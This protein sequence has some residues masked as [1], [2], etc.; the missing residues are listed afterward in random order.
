FESP[1]GQFAIFVG[2]VDNG[3]PH[4]FEVWING[5]EQPRGLGAIAKTLSMDMRAR[6]TK[7]LRMKLDVLARAGGDAFDCAM[8]PD[9]K[10]V[11]VPSVV[12]AFARIVRYRIDFLGALANADGRSPVFDA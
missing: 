6:D 12:A 10:S 7:W 1:A 4:A 8:P 2:H 5:N 11:R 9:G 3:D